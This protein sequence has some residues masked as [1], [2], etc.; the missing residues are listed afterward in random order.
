V[1]LDLTAY[2]WAVAAA[3]AA[4]FGF[5]LISL[6]RRDVSSVDSLWSL[7]FLLILGVYQYLVDPVGPRRWL[8][9]LLV[10]VWALRLSI[11]ITLRN[12]GKPEDARYQAIRRNNEPNFAFK[13]I[14][15]VFGF[16]AALAA[17]ISLPLLVASSDS[18][19]L[20]WLDALGV[21]LWMAGMFFEVTG[22]L[23]LARFRADPASH[24]KVLDTGLWRL[25]RHPNYFGEF[26]LWWGYFCLA[27][28]AG[29]WWTIIS[30]LL[31]SLLLLKVSGVVL[32]EKDIGLR[33]PGY[34]DYIRRT[35]AF[36]PG[37]PRSDGAA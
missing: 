26:T 11:Y 25:T 5:W 12:H 6:V 31:M 10:S 13:S 8:I 24:G 3:L 35:N 27:A 4:A 14:Y 19:A 9:L 36:F 32:L 1:A 28:A 2:G 29:G 23:Q 22:D 20:G 16:Q 7:M 18:S 15:I 33:R 17:I 21:A 37:P 34:V 30:P